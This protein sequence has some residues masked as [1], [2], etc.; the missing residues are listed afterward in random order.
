MKRILMAWVFCG[1]G[2]TFSAWG[3]TLEERVKT[4]EAEVAALRQQVA[5][6]QGAQHEARLAEL[7]RKLAVLAEELERLRLGELGEA[8]AVPR[9][10][11]LAP[12]ASKVYTAK[13]GV[14]VAG[15]GELLYQNFA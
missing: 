15:Y 3:Q 5:A 6:A 7:E 8:M 2:V 10:L 11:G 1:F 14:T 13:P 4:L 12:A 9:A